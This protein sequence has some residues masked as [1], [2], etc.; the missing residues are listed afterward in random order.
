MAID[1][2]TAGVD[3][4]RGDELVSWLQKED[5]HSPHRDKIVSGIGG[6]AAL[7]RADFQKYKKPCLVSATDGVGTKVLVASQF[8]S[9][10]GIGQDLVAMCVNDLICC[11]AEPLFFLDYFA[12]GKLDLNIAKPFLKGLRQAC[13][14]AHCALIGGETAEM[15][16]VYKPKDFDCAGFAVGVVDEEDIWGAHKVKAG[17]QLIAFPSSGFHSNGYSLLRRVFAE[18]L[19]EWRELLLKPT[20]LYVSLVQNL[21]K[22]A[23]IHALAH[24]TGGGINNVLRVIPDG[25]AINLKPWQVPAPFL[26]V[27]KRAEFGWSELL[28]TLNCGIGLVLITS[29][30]QLE[31]VETFCRNHQQEYWHFGGVVERPQKNWQL[32]ISAMNEGLSD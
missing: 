14:Q 20:E 25:L 29:A 15:P 5:S 1:Y 13:H 28:S 26:E 24:I 21:R 6:F 12:T 2:K 16:G 27:K 11:G 30:D 7:F 19:Q 8:E 22:E 32:D 23:E 9:Y 4:A 10:E 3:I 18:D 17:D 31:K